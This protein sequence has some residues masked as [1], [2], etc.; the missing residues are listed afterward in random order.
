[1]TIKICVGLNT[2]NI[3]TVVMP[4][5]VKDGEIYYPK[6]VTE[7]TNVF[8]LR[9]HHTLE[10]FLKNKEQL[11]QGETLVVPLGRSEKKLFGR[12]PAYHQIMYFL[13]LGQG[14]I[15]TLIVDI[16]Q[17]AALYDIDNFALPMNRCDPPFNQD[18]KKVAGLMIQ[19]LPRFDPIFEIFIALDES[20]TQALQ[21]FTD[22]DC[23]IEIPKL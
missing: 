20:K 17:K 13:D 23:T 4:F 2:V 7:V 14:C 8:G 22:Q 6:I 16:I 5:T 3:A 21:F 11:F 12:K 10:K 9:S 18:E 1:M 15:E 19:E